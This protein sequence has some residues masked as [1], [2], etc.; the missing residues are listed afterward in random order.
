MALWESKYFNVSVNVQGETLSAKIIGEKDANIVKINN[1]VL[2]IHS[3]DKE[4]DNTA[5]DINSIQVNHGIKEV[6]D[7]PLKKRPKIIL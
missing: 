5:R 3:I 2:S 7:V 4:L 6:K 1:L